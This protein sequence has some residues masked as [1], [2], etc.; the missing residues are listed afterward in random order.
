[1]LVCQDTR[2]ERAYTLRRT[3]FLREQVNFGWAVFAPPRMRL[4]FPTELM[5]QQLHAIAD[6]QYG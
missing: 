3:A 1:L 6:A 4:N 2:K 5:G